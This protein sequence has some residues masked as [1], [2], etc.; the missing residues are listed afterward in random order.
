[1]R[2][3]AHRETLIGASPEPSVAAAL[4]QTI[5]LCRGLG[6]EVIDTAPPDIEGRVIGEAFFALGGAG[7]NMMAESMSGM[8]G[9]PIGEADLE[10]F[11]LSLM[12]WY[13]TLP[14]GAVERAMAVI[15]AAAAKMIDYVSRFDVIL[16]PTIPCE[17]PL[18]GFLAPTLDYDTILRHMEII[19]GYTPIHNMAGIPAMSV[20]LFRSAA[21]LPIGSHFAAGPGAEAT[22]LALAYELEAAA[23]WAGS[24]PL[25]AA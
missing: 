19:A 8:L 16:C 7:M 22:L 9:R 17:P 2:I 18:L 1:L 12:A 23:P 24:Y 25:L 14:A 6:H 15:Q 20:P 5:S 13:R 21:G 10:P 11:T 3:G 4:D